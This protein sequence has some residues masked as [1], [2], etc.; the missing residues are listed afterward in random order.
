MVSFERSGA[1]VKFGKALL[2]FYFVPH[3]LTSNAEDVLKVFIFYK[4]RTR[5][6]KCHITL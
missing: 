1:L 5:E 4:C 3:H 2:I 6:V